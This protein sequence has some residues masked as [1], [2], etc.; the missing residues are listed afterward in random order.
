MWIKEYFDR[1]KGGGENA[2]TISLHVIFWSGLASIIG[3]GTV[4]YI[5]AKFFQPLRFNFI[6]RFIRS[7]GG[8]YIRRY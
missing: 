8:S 3:I 1:M 5:S 6:N 2:T 4:A 7:V